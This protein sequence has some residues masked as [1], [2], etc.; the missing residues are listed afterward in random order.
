MTERDPLWTL[1]FVVSEL[2]SRGASPLTTKARG[3]RGFAVFV[4]LI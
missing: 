3:Y 1:A 2:A 4:E